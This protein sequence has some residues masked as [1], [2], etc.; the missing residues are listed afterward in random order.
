M[1]IGIDAG[2]TTIKGLLLKNNEMIK[3]IRHPNDTTTADT[4]LNSITYVIE[5]LVSDEDMKYVKAISLSIAGQVNYKK[6]VLKNAPNMPLKNFNFTK[7]FKER[8]NK[9]SYIDNDV[10]CAAIAEG[11]VYPS[12]TTQLFIFLGTGIGGALIVNGKLLRGKNNLALEIGHLTYKDKTLECGCGKK[13]CY[14]AYAGAKSMIKRYQNLK[15]ITTS[16]NVKVIEKAYREK[17]KEALI[18]FQDALD[19]LG[20]LT[21]DLI[22]LINPEYIIFGGGVIDYSDLI[23]DSIK[24]YV[25]NNIRFEK[26]SNI[27]FKNSLFKDKSNAYGAIIGFL[28]N[29]I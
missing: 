28:R 6:G 8:Y 13:G 3:F 9:L 16:L 5:S 15:G 24:D 14:E 19:A 27:K 29:S 25:K 20:V 17:E 2:G 22:T 18:V 1:Y 21:N 4:V 12:N 7:F 10:N 11:S 23:L 26:F